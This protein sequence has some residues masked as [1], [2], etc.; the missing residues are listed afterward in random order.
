MNIGH[1]MFRR[2][3]RSNSLT[4]PND[5]DEARVRRTFAGKMKTARHLAAAGLMTFTALAARDQQ[6][7]LPQVS[8]V[9]A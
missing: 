2:R 6:A 3:E 8:V 4:V 9:A 1:A 5:Y 7:Q